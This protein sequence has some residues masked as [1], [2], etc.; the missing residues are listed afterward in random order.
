MD[1]LFPQ[2]Q[3][4]NGLRDCTEGNPFKINLVTVFKHG[5][6][7]SKASN[8]FEFKNSC[9]LDIHKKPNALKTGSFLL[10]KELV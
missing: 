10:R 7:Y 4:I 8:G 6:V 2:Q 1:L 3:E 9:P 5:Q